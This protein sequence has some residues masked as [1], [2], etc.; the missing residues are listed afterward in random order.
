MHYCW[1][2]HRARTSVSEGMA[3]ILFVVYFFTSVPFKVPLRDNENTAKVKDLQRRNVQAS[4]AEIRTHL[5]E[6]LCRL[7]KGE[8]I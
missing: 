7:S 5:N 6:N 4:F 2:K 8:N 3:V 1:N